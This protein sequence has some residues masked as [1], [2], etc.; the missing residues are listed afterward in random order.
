VVSRQTHALLHQIGLPEFS[1]MDVGDCVRIAV[2]LANDRKRLAN[3][4][5][6]LRHKMGT[7]PLMNVKSY[8]HQ[9][10]STLI[11]LYSRIEAKESPE[12][13]TPIP[14][15]PKHPHPR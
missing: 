4:R 10:E 8:A 13:V 1:A 2:E 14:T 3:L 9:L 11:D 6:A 12:S 15:H 5:T 7:S